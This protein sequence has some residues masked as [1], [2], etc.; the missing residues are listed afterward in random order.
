LRVK[1]LLDT[2]TC[3][4]A[5]RNL[6]PVVQRLSALSPTD[7][8]VST[9]TAYELLTGVEK[10]ADPRRERSKVKRLLS[11]VSELA[12]DSAAAA[13]AARIRAQLEALGQVISPYDLLLAGHAMSAKLVGNQ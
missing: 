2:N 9:I 7:C 4:S 3:I 10:C 1:Y 5:R 13:E 12:F 6:H 11:T 8:A